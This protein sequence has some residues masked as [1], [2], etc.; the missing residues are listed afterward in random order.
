MQATPIAKSLEKWLGI[1]APGAYNQA[2]TN[3]AWAFEPLASMWTEEITSDSSDEEEDSNITD[4]PPDT[5]TTTTPTPA[6]V[7]PVQTNHASQPPAS[8]AAID[9]CIDAI[10]TIAI[11]SKTIL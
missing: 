2:D 3:K 5:A 7:P 1:L 4:T 8:K 10:D 9:A 6:Q 11:H